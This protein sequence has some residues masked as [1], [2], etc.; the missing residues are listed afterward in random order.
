M[1]LEQSLIPRYHHPRAGGDPARG[2]AA[3]INVLRTDQTPAYAGVARLSF[4]GLAIQ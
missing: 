2:E 4:E 3:F 1:G